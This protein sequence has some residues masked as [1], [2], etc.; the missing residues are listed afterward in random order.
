MEIKT[1]DKKERQTLWKGLIRLVLIL[2][3][4][5][6]TLLL[7]AGRWNWWEAWAYT[8]TGLVVLLGSRA[9]MIR[10]H[11]DLALERAQAH[12]KEDVKEWDRFLM[13]FTALVGPF[14]SWI[15]AGLD[16]RFDWSPD[17]PN[18]IQIFALIVI[19]IGSLIG[20]WAMI[21]NRYFSSQVRIQADRGQQVVQD[22]PYSFVRHPGYAGGLLSWLAAPIFFSSYWLLIPMVLVMGASVVRT[23]L[24]D[25]TLQDELPGY[26]AYAE[27]VKFRLIPGVW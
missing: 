24:E 13:P 4:M 23:T 19:Q 14:L 9:F 18:W 5:L 21:A 20:S 2:P 12:E 8:I 22:G 17:L 15:V 6:G 16:Q 1:L 10:K 25:Q 26:Q 3:V 11:P 27:K 7:S